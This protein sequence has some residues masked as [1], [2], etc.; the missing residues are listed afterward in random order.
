MSRAAESVRV[1]DVDVYVVREGSGRP[2]LTV[3]GGPGLGHSYLEPIGVLATD[4]TKREN[5]DRFEV[6]QYDQRGSG[7]SGSGDI[8][9]L[10]IAGAVEDLEE[11][12]AALGLERISLLGHSIGGHVAYLYASRYPERVN[13]LVLFATAPPLDEALANEMW[14]DMA[15]RRTPQDDAEQAAI[16]R[17][18][19]F[20][21]RE[22]MAVERYI[23]NV[24]TPFFRDRATIGRMTFDLT[25]TSV[26]S[27]LDVG[28]EGFLAT[29][30]EMDPMGSLSRIG[31]P[32]LVVHAELDPTPYPFSRMLADTIPGAE[33]ALLKGAS[34]FAFIEDPDAFSEVVGDFLRRVTP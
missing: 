27:I 7:R 17:S 3:H 19:E 14:L 29:L 31:C 26:A 9:K 30:P 25:P 18:D 2:L 21:R 10:T 28:E 20:R 24:Y 8:A 32:T 5:D 16:R 22:P 23:L 34:H 4:G 12:R 13:A 1:D 15:S 11:L 33:F 6:I